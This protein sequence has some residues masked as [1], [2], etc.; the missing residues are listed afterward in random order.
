MRRIR[1]QLVDAEVCLPYKKVLAIGVGMIVRIHF[2]IMISP[3]RFCSFLGF[4]ASAC[5]TTCPT[6]DNPSY[7]VNVTAAQ[8][9]RGVQ[10]GE[11]TINV[12]QYVEWPL[13]VSFKEVRSP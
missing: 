5:A 12:D 2:A 6:S 4:L 10:N 1:C 13:T 9:P 8:A 3:M 7:C 11:Y